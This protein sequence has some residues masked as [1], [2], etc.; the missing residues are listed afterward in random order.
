MQSTSMGVQFEVNDLD[1]SYELV[2]TS[3][4]YSFQYKLGKGSD[5]VNDIGEA[6]NEII[7]LK[8][9]YGS[10]EV[11]VFAVS[12]IGIRSEF[13]LGNVNIS[14]PTFEG[15]FTF[16]NLRILEG[17]GGVDDTLN[18]EYAPESPGDELIVTQQFAGKSV[19][20]AWELIPPIGHPQEGQSVDT[21]LLSDV[22]FSGIIVN[23]KNDGQL[24]GQQDLGSSEALAQSLLSNDVVGILNNYRDFSLNLN[25][26]AFNDL[27]LQ[28]NISVE[29]IAVDSLGGTCT[30][31]L[32]GYNPPPEFSNFSYNLR[33]SDI[34]FSWFINDLD[35]KNIDVNILAVGKNVDL[36]DTE[37]Y[38]SSVN[39]L[40]SI[41][42]TVDSNK[43]WDSSKNVSY[44]SGD[45][46]L[47]KDSVYKALSSHQ[48]SFSAHPI[49]GYPWENLGS[50][51]FF[52]TKSE[53][54]TETVFSNTQLWGYKYYYTF[55]AFDD[56][57]AGDV[58][59]LG[60]DGILQVQGSEDARLFPYESIVQIGNL[61]YI[62]DADDFVF[63]WNVVDQDGNAVDLNQYKFAFKESSLPT[64]LGLSGSLYDIQSNQYLTGITQGENGIGLN[65]DE[66]GNT[67]IV[68][69]LASTKV[70][71]TFRFTRELNNQVYDIGGFPSS[72]SVF[73]DAVYY[74]QDDHVSVTEILY[75]SITSQVDAGQKTIRPEYYDWEN[76]EN[77]QLGDCAVYNGNIYQLNDSCGPAHTEGIFN[78]ETLHASGD[79]VVAPINQYKKFYPASLYGTILTVVNSGEFTTNLT[80]VVDNALQSLSIKINDQ[81][82][83][84]A[85][86]D[87][88]DKT[89]ILDT[90]L[91]ALPQVGDS[92]EI[93]G[94]EY[95]GGSVVVH[96]NKLF[97]S[98]GFQS[99]D[100]I[101]TP[102]ND[103]S[104]WTQVSA[105]SQV[106]CEIY[107]CINA[108]NFNA[109]ESD[110]DW[111]IQDP[112]SSDKFDGYISGY[113]ERVNEWSSEQDFF[114]S[115]FV[116]YAN[117]LWSGVIDSGPSS[118]TGVIVP[119][120][121]SN[122][123]VNNVGGQDIVF[124]YN[125][126]DIVY[127]LGAVYK[128]AAN[129]PIGA[130]IEAISNPGSE[131]LSTYQG[132][133]W[134]PYWQR[135]T[136]YDDVVFGHVGIPESGKRSVA[137]ELGIVDSN[138]QVFSL[139]RLNAYNQQ[140]SILPEGFNVDSTGETT[141]IKFNFNYA[142][143]SQ[144]KT[145]KV[146]LYRSSEPNFEIT[147]ADGL[148]QETIGEG[149]NLVKVTLGAADAT[150]GEKKTQIV[151]SPPIPKINGVDQVTGYYYKILPF[152]DFGSGDLFGVDDNQEDLDQC[153]VYPKNYSTNNPN[154]LPG[155]VYRTTSD[156]I[157]GSVVG[158]NGNV[159][160]ENFF[161]NW[162]HPE[163]Q[164]STDDNG[165][166]L[167]NNFIPNDLSH[168]EV[169]ISEY[170]KLELGSLNVYLKNQKDPLQ[171]I[172][173]SND[174]GYRRIRGDI[175]SAGPI[176]PELQ[177]PASGITN[178]TQAFTISANGVE[179]ETSYPGKT[180]DTR[181]FWVRA[182][183]HAGNKSPF[184]GIS[185]LQGD[186]HEITG[187]GLTLGVAS[188]T[189][190]EDFEINMTE[191]FGNTIALV[192]NNPFKNN[193]N[194]EGEISWTQH[195]LFNEGTGFIVDE[196]VDGTSDGYVWWDRNDENK[197][198]NID[199]YYVKL[200][201]NVTQTWGESSL[202]ERGQIIEW[203]D[204]DTDN[205]DQLNLIMILH[206]L[207]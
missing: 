135:E 12:N 60:E 94:F 177:D 197:S 127:A 44:E 26:A 69:G 194:T 77:Y 15:S 193:S 205:Q 134:I 98:R 162:F 112:E 23:I 196:S 117:D 104:K 116:V 160:F 175:S 39:Y 115:D 52:E 114:I 61:S 187:L 33:G 131:S 3:D 107:K 20:L 62:E 145:T 128:A 129:D 169:W 132:T 87:G 118:E 155:P 108:N 1:A 82:K 120:S 54:L 32:S 48:S 130:P 6:A 149:S 182:V 4:N 57:G 180:N 81:T 122:V 168:Y 37:N 191:S 152:D 136:I 42:E 27:D 188:A 140:P 124:D 35:Y 96:N 36:F 158:F 184:T 41:N 190:I 63:N 38:D 138:N 176:P 163:G 206:L 109:N 151:D 97:R 119:G 55:Q 103:P 30:G 67:Q 5:L 88:Y 34:S 201:G 73:D 110:V 195:Y 90:D 9:N 172:D 84:V 171:P 170:N 24:I 183:D 80:N 121:D 198:L 148:P 142:F 181:Y 78:F 159:A 25:T 137:I 161:L 70:F 102:G 203:S 179:V 204:I 139:T 199:D 85:S 164:I 200:S 19:Q 16:N 150:F 17:F 72:Y 153:L 141:K 167:Y 144:E 165:K 126:G 111:Q 47:W 21:E 99:G 86:Y 143:Q 10:F 83:T 207:Y 45:F 157:P 95:Q 31:T 100:T 91:N 202:I 13:I 147:G 133:E 40:Q 166:I 51:V 89:I 59:L 113:S 14:P 28:R 76:S 174:K 92:F 50:K 93:N 7:P 125:Q 186:T 105:F 106:P 178:A 146:N 46:V 79:L 123:W 154:G 173:F 8:G 58:M 66:N 75:K 68:G 64:M 185:G 49:N 101:A 29:L 11:K 156:D 43:V 74:Q 22:F 192:P 189:D 71:D 53:S 2:G 65:L 56:F 18:I